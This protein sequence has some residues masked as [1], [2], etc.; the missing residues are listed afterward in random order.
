MTNLEDFQRQLKSFAETVNAFKSEAVQ[1]RVIDALL[2]QL[3]M[4][5]SPGIQRDSRS[6]RSRVKRIKKAQAPSVKAGTPTAK[7]KS[8]RKSSS[9]PGAF[10]MI[11]QLL[12]DGFFKSGRTIGAIVE[13]CGT[14]RGHHFKANEC[15]PSLL[16][17]LRDGKLQRKKNKEG[18]YEYTQTQIAT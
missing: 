2:I 17:L 12:E 9:S 18:Q 7:G 16:R 10:A 4:E 1:L 8:T 5:P 3:G 6:R 15:S 11:S 14:S 13:H